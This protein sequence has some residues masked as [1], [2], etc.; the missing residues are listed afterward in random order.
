MC[1]K[2]GSRSCSLL[3]RVAQP[4]H[5]RQ[6]SIRAGSTSFVLS[7]SRPKSHSAGSIPYYCTAQS[8][9]CYHHSRPPLL[10]YAYTDDHNLMTY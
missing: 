6:C 2:L 8:Y 5:W 4:T 1:E 10:G 3:C 7:P 9:S